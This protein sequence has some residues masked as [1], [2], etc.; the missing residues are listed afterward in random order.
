MNTTSQWSAPEYDILSINS[1]EALLNPSEEGKAPSPLERVGVRSA[2][3]DK[4]FF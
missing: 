1:D 2:T 3:S 4:I